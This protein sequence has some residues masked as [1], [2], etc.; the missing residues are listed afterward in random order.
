VI[1]RDPLIAAWFVN[2]ALLGGLGLVAVPILIHLLSRRQYR[3]IRWGA[4]R[5]LLEAEKENR[6][7]RRFEQ[8]L[9]V[10]LR[11][12]AMGLLAL[13]VARPFVQPGLVASLLGGRSQIERIILLD[14]SASLAFRSG[15]TQDFALLREAAERLLRWLHDGAGG[16][17][18]T[19]H[20]TSAPDKPL[21][22]KQRLSPAT[23]EDLCV[24]VRALQ[25]VNLP[26]RPRR[27]LQT[28]AEDLRATG[29][30]ARAD[31]YVLSDF[32]RSEWLALDS[33]GAA[34][35]EP[36]GRLETD[37]LRVVLIAGGA[38]ARDNVAL[39]D[40]RFERPQT[41]AGLP[42]VVD[43]TVVNYSRRSLGGVQVQVEVNGALLPSAPLEPIPPG[44]SRM[45]SVEVTFPDEGFSE[46]EL[47]V[48]A[49][50]GLPVDN[51]R[52]LS[53][54]VKRSLAVLLVD[55]Q[56]ATDPVR[57]EVY[58]LRNALA[59]AGA[60]SSGLSVHT[61]DV[62]EIEARPL[63]AF[64][65]VVL[66]NVAPPG[67]GAVA[68]LERYVRKG[69]GLLF[70]LGDEVDDA[71]EYNRV[72]HA[73]GEGLL[74]LPLAEVRR[75]RDPVALLRSGEH[76]VTAMFPADGAA[77]LES[78]HFW[79]YYR[80]SATFAEEHR[81]DAEQP[82]PATLAH[83]ADDAQSPALVERVFGRGRVLLFT[84]SVDLD[85]N[86]WPR[87]MDGSY[88]VTMLELVQY[89][90][91]R[92]ADRCSFATGET[93]TLSLVP[94]DYEPGGVFRAPASVD[95][96][97]VEARV[98]GPVAA[99]GAPVALEGPVATHLGTYTAELIRRDGS[100]ELRPL[101]VN[102][103]PV[104][105]DLTVARAH[106][107]DVALG[108][109]PHEYVEAS[110]AFRRDNEQARRE[111][112]PA[113]LVALVAILMVEQGLAWWFGTPRHAAR[114]RRRWRLPRLWFASGVETSAPAR[115]AGAGPGR[116][117]SGVRTR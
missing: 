25:P 108:S 81:P 65:C 16:D 11:C 15:T 24:Q 27:A 7:R 1:A 13:L 103:D 60:F 21:S 17:L 82:V 44:E 107:L 61:A 79:T 112:W 34:V 32:Q 117:R 95:E 97:A 70:F 68:A 31:L 56:P 87:A 10:A 6:R 77:L 39:L 73:N 104:E 3:R 71:D 94:E 93:L 48:D 80:C 36:L 66:C 22:A 38:T 88:V 85:W 50:D 83:F 23:L 49:I 54:P 69:G 72:F 29:K 45:V 40:A 47:A 92:S 30:T 102:L 84:S 43:A 91:R 96:P 52:R 46:L 57:D 90:A 111:L 33:G 78:V 18:V 2:P 20:L 5:F 59:P 86:D 100:V 63:D 113:V 37:A 114:R 115:T 75:S 98:R 89:A 55:G 19:L 51:T 109:V 99:V 12:L 28:V 101:S 58:F 105:S 64:D 53:L 4:M 9:L 14:D 26:A 110:E 74:P 8:W 41:I 35:F 42:A 106:E 67:P 76:P 116:H 62:E